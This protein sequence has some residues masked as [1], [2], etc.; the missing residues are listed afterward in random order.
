VRNSSEGALDV[1]DWSQAT[2]KNEREGGKWRK[3]WKKNLV[4]SI[5]HK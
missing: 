5:M 2:E 4:K 1:V 3:E